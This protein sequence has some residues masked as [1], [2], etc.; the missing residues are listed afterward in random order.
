MWVLVGV[1]ITSH[2][3]TSTETMY[4]LSGIAHFDFYFMNLS[5]FITQSWIGYNIGHKKKI[6]FHFKHPLEAL[7]L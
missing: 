2:L 1:D 6:G 3:K 5:L 4:A 7:T